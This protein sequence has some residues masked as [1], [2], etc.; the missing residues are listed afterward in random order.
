MPIQK[1]EGR[2][3][4]IFYFKT[5]HGDKKVVFPDFIRRTV[6]LADDS[7]RKY[8]VVQMDYEN[9]HIFIETDMDN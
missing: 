9:I 6:V 1:I 2:A 7:I 4:D 3:D 8:M 5:A